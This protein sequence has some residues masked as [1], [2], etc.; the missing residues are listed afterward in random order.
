MIS[1]GL[2]P[3]GNNN[4]EDLSINLEE[5]P[6]NDLDTYFDYSS[7]SKIYFNSSSQ[8]T[9]YIEVFFRITNKE[10]GQVVHIR[11]IDFNFGNL[12]HGYNEEHVYEDDEAV[13][14]GDYIIGDSSSTPS[15]SD[16][17]NW[18]IKDYYDL[19]STD[20]FVWKFFKT[21]LFE[22]PSWITTPL[23]LLIF[24]V[25]IITIYRFIRGA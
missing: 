3:H 19:V 5:I 24:G 25:V 18:E 22:L 23:F 21:I 6:I 17:E 9:Y 7:G 16:I 1:V 12:G 10:T 4:L 20:N 8:Y 2:D 11:S 13:D 14:N 15:Y